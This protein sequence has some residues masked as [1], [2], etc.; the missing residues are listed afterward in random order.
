MTTEWGYG[1]AG[2]LPP[3]DERH[4]KFAL[5]RKERGF[6][7]TETWNLD[8]TF[9][10]FII[11]RLQALKEKHFCHPPSITMEEWDDIIQEMID[12]FSIHLTDDYI[13]ENF[14]KTQKALDLFNKW[15]F[16]LWW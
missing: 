10:K 4:E 16:D 9:C 6:D 1:F 12:G 5:Q 14:D 7:D 15:F 8:V 11:P 3:D 13:R 2:D